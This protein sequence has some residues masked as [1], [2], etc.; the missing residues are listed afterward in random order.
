MWLFTKHGFFSAVC[1]RQDDGSHGQPVAPDRVMVRARARAHLEALQA[2]FP[3]LL[4]GCEV[5]ESPD[6]DYRFRI[7][8]EKRVWGEVLAA[9]GEELDYGAFKSEIARHQGRAGAAYDRALHEAWDV[10]YRCR[11]GLTDSGELEHTLCWPPGICA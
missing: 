7:I 5:P 11:R 6:A 8:V 2:R 3:P 4:G 1:A 10:M 9:L